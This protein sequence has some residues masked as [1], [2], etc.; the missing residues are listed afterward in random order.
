MTGAMQCCVRS[1]GRLNRWSR[2]TRERTKAWRG[3][4]RTQ[5]LNS[6]KAIM[7]T[8]GAIEKR[9][10]SNTVRSFLSSLMAG[11]EPREKRRLLAAFS[12]KDARGLESP[13]RVVSL[14][15]ANEAK[16]LCAMLV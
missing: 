14:M 8:R 12:G 16:E 13:A 11:M 1:R 15:S 10:S 5:I 9:R 2:W 3:L 4:W 7:A 6:Q